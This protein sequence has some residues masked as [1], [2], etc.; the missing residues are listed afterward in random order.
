MFEK[1][2]RHITSE[3]LQRGRVEL[4]GEGVVIEE[5]SFLRQWIFV[6][7]MQSVI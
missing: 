1:S 3:C 5:K 7:T 4:C 6:I 2:H